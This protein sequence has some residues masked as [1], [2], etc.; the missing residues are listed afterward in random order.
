MGRPQVSEWNQGRSL[1]LTVAI[2]AGLMLSGGAILAH[3]ESPEHCQHRIQHAEHELHEAV[4]RHGRDSRQA[5]R[6]RV[7]LRE[8]R[9][10]CWRENHRWW[11]EREQ[12][13]HDQH[14]WNDHDRD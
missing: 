4:E 12:R 1:L 5:E 7:E 10:R 14:D 8:A 11:D 6:K 3:A 2:G 9:E 13:W